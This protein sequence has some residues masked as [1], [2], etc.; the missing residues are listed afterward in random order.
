MLR[1]W[2]ILLKVSED[3]RKPVYIRIADSIIEAIKDGSLKQGEALPGSREMASILRVNRNTIV[4]IYDILLSEGWLVSEDRKG[5]FVSE[6]HLLTPP[7]TDKPFTNKSA[8]YNR[9]T[10]ILFDH[11]L[12]DPA[13]T[14]IDEIAKAY[15]R[16]FGQ[17]TK[18]N[19]L[20]INNESGNIKFRE[21][22]S[23][24]LNFSKSMNTSAEEICITRGSQMAFFLTA[25]CLLEQGDI[26][27]VENPG[28]Q[29]AWNA[30]KHAGAK[31]IPIPVDSEGIDVEIIK[32]ILHKTTVKAIYLTP[33]HQFPTTVALSLNRR[34]KLIELSN[35]YGFTIIEDD[36]DCHF[37]FGQRPKAPLCSHK[38]LNNFR[39][40][41]T[42][43]H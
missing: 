40:C 41:Y 39:Q 1:P 28:Y 25:H 17:K 12:P 24:M 19:L 15:R 23:Q 14:P 33:H 5:T 11:G 18:R 20:D 43:L 9:A 30:F 37:Y 21:A 29:P 22:I 32:S 27:L 42:K 36:Y 26:V 31:L 4:K 38:E 13:F 8:N 16:I 34:L 35:Q 2:S 3:K 6:H 10:A 7:D